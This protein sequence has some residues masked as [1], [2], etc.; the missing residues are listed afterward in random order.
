MKDTQNET[1]TRNI[2]LDYVGVKDVA[3]PIIVRD[4]DKIKQHVQANVS[5]FVNLSKLQKGVHMSHLVDPLFA[6]TES[7]GMDQL[8]ELAK[9]IKNE[10]SKENEDVT[11]KS[12]R[13]TLDFKYFVDKISP[14]VKVKSML[15]YNVR[16]DVVVGDINCKSITV[17]VPV[18][19]CCPCSL[20]L[21]NGVAAHNQR[22]FITITTYQKLD[23]KKVIWFEDIIEAAENA[24]SCEIYP[25]LRRPDEK[26]V[27]LKM[28]KHAKFVEDVVRDAVINMKN[29]FPDVKL[30]V[31]C[32][33]VESIHDHSAYAET[34]VGEGVSNSLM[35]WMQ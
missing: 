8:V 31:S 4:R 35:R 20:E 13:L 33:N 14:E 27:T 11:T 10:Q 18:S 26:Y 12:C 3:I 5:V 17:R 22:G 9:E 7:Y 29:K 21:C 28:F 32:E 15:G 16:T 19:T 2:G 25:V 24:G 6:L 34:V 1:D 23:D 30:K